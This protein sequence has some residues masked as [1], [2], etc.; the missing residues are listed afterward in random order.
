[1]LRRTVLLV[2]LLLAA[3]S[4]QAW[5]TERVVLVIIDGLRYSEGLGDPTHA[6]VPQMA[7]LAAQ[8]AIVE[9]FTNQGVTYTNHAVPAIWCGGYTDIF[10]F[11]DPECGGSNN[12]TELPSM[13]EYFRKQLQKAPEDC[14]YLL[15][16]VG[17]PWRGSMHPDY[18]PE[19]W[20]LYVM[21][22]YTD[23]SVWVE[24]QSL[25]ANESPELLLVYLADVDHYGHAGVWADYL[26]AIETADAIVGALWTRLQALP[27]YAG[28]TTLLVTNDH[29]RHTTNWTGHGD[30]CAG[31]RRIQL[32]AVGP[33]TPA[34][35][36]STTPRQIPDIVPSIG[37]LLGFTSE[38]ATGA[39]MSELFS[40][41]DVGE[42]PAAGQT[43]AAWPNPFRGETSL[44]LSSPLASAAMLAVFDV[45]GRRVDRLELP[46][47]AA[48]L[49]WT[50]PA[51]LASGVYFARVDV[52][53]ER[54]MRRLVLLR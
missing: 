12:Y 52:A 42:L 21:A 17:C 19:W 16:D 18:G 38:Y 47:G 4:A 35:L 49:T 11:T 40:E 53:G 1:M 51:E 46:A 41:T 30:G 20:P 6:H 15:K 13:F 33:D 9:P 14:I 50:P 34:G 37:L 45:A 24:A 7:A 22:G 25:L 36:V 8:G 2:T 31:C 54:L 26:E 29:G 44:R 23:A 5:Q 39:P 28:K 48:A 43:L 27:A 3:A 32:L 10:E